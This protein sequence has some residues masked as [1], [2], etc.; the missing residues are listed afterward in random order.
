MTQQPQTIFLVGP[1]A[2]GKTAVSI[3][4]AQKLGAE[5]VSAD[6]MQ[7]YRGMDIGTAK[8][9]MEERRGVP[10]H[11]ID[12]ADITESFDVAQYRRMATTAIAD[13][14]RRGKIALVVGGTGLYVRALLRGLDEMPRDEELRARLENEPLERLVARLKSLDPLA[15]SKLDLQNKRRVTRALEVFELTGKSIV[16]QQSQWEGAPSTASEH[17]APNGHTPPEKFMGLNRHRDDLYRRC[18]TRVDEMFAR[19]LVAEVQAL[20]VRGLDKNRTALQAVGYKEVA[21]H[22]RGEMLLAD[23]IAAVK[24]AT[25]HLAKRQLT[26]FRREPSLR[27]IE[28]GESET[29][30]E[31]AD[32]VLKEIEL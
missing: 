31:T 15:A 21:A 6:S 1:T 32:R 18:D 13:I 16:A 4:V 26:W 25:R 14:H 29:V 28:V 22:L 8:P 17:D 23:C 24:I 27:W 20:L 2:V 3:L 5:I 11:L 9:S 12:V 10:H 19:G 30:A 7:I